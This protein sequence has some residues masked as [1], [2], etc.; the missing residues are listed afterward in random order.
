LC[1]ESGHEAFRQK[2]KQAT[3]LDPS[4]LMVPIHIFV[5]QI[6]ARPSGS[7]CRIAETENSI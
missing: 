1:L 7:V 5:Q 2:A 3:P 4:N 6:P